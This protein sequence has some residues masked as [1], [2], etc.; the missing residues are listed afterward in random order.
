MINSIHT[1]INHYNQHKAYFFSSQFLVCASYFVKYIW[2][3]FFNIK[4]NLVRFKED[5]FATI[6][7]SKEA[8]Y[9]RTLLFDEGA[10]NKETEANYVN[11]RICPFIKI[12]KDRLSVKY[13][14]KA[15]DYKTV[16]VS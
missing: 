16:A 10:K 6:L 11:P 8:E 9:L 5:C 2:Y 7:M 4:E 14:G 3:F 15:Q 13:I 12:F 1:L